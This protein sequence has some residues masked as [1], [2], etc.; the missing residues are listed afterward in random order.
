[1]T[2]SV[3][4]RYPHSADKVYSTF[5]DEQYLREKYTFLG[6]RNYQFL[7]KDETGQTISFRQQ[8][9]VHADVPSFAKKIM[10][11]WNTLEEKY[12]WTDNGAEKSLRFDSNLQGQP[13]TITGTASLR[14]DGDETVETISLDVDVKVPLI[15]GKLRKKAEEDARESLIREAEFNTQYLART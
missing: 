13:V 4:N 8:R 2:V 3:T 7:G 9:D 11:E 1:M 12:V 5:T 6:D 15:G 10:S 14:E